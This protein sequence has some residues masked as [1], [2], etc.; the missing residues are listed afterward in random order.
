MKK[1]VRKL[2]KIS[3]HSYSIIIPKSLIKTFGWK[4]RQKLEVVFGGK[5]HELKI[6]D[7]KPKS[8]KTKA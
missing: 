8:S 5:K 2:T 3:T 6:R 4:E 1:F 7:W